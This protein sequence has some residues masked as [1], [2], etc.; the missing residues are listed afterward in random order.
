[1]AISNGRIESI[2]GD[3]QHGWVTFWYKDHPDDKTWCR[4][5]LPGVEFLRR[6][7]AHVP[8]LFAPRK[9]L[10]FAERT[11]TL[12]GRILKEQKRGHH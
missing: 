2:E 9:G 1:V 6:F 10:L 5:R 12:V 8:S 7:C 11:T 3:G 4:T